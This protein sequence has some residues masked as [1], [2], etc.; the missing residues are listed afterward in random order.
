MNTKKLGGCLLAML[1]ALQ[2]IPASAKQRSNTIIEGNITRTHATTAY[3]Y[4]VW[5]GNYEEVAQQ[6]IN[7]NGNFAFAVPD[8]K[9]G[10]YYVGTNMYQK[11]EVTRLYV[12]PGDQLELQIS[13]TA[14]TVTG[15]CEQEKVLN[16]WQQL[17]RNVMHIG[18]EFW[19]DQFGYVKFFPA[20]EQLQPKATAFKQKIHTKDPAFDNY[21][22]WLVDNDME[23]AA[24]SLLYTPR[25]AHAS[26]EERPD[27]YKHIVQADKYTDARV[28]CLGDGVRRMT[29][30]SQFN[31]MEKS[32]KREDYFKCSMESFSNDTLRGV[33]VV[34][35]LR[36]YRTLEAAQEALT[37][38]KQYLVTDSLRAQ[39][40]RGL[41]QMATFKRGEKAFEFNFK[42]NSGK[43]VAL[44]DFRG[45]VV[46]IDTWATWCGPCRQEL[47]SLKKLEESYKDDARMA[48]VSISIDEEKDTQ[49]WMDFIKTEKL[50]GT[51][52][53]T[54]GWNNDFIKYYKITGI[55]RFILIDQEGNLVNADA[56]RP[57][58]GDELNG[59]LKKTLDKPK[60]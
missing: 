55:P 32:V 29:F 22:R 36:S 7:S 13:D 57:S 1:A 52:L 47:P 33:A 25:T 48:F 28:L 5:E 3:L 23:L 15:G 49:K 21:M 45:K 42:D 40:T 50:G 26:K 10:F 60:S 51:Q 38:F 27:Y 19:A 2:W 16:E 37:P 53:H 59:L 6:H 18:I 58:S 43:Q 4:S 17:S 20:L 12:K 11:M 56:P 34:A 54:P 24:I 8:L 14:T 39:Y 44:K 41:S 9:A 30:Y 35:Q 46:Y 31:C